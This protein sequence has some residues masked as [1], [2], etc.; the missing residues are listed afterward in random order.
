MVYVPPLKSRHRRLDMP[1]LC[2]EQQSFSED[3]GLRVACLE[4]ANAQLPNASRDEVVCEAQRRYD[5]LS[6]FLL[7]GEAS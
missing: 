3:Y 4:H 6:A 5:A 1:T 2:A 7:V